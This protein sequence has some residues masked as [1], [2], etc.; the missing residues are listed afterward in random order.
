VVREETE[1]EFQ[2]KK[3]KKDF[4]FFSGKTKIVEKSPKTRVCA[5]CVGT[6]VSGEGG[7][8]RLKSLGNPRIETVCPQRV[9]KEE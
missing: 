8:R 9:K 3:R 4:C 7:K 5:R 1:R 2:K 6:S